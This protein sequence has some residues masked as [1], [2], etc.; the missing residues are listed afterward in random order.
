[1]K[2]MNASKLLPKLAFYEKLYIWSLLSEPLLFFV[3]LESSVLGIPITLS[4]VLQFSF[5]FILCVKYISCKKTIIIYDLLSVQNQRI[6]IYIFIVFLSS[7]A[8]L[9]SGAY[10]YE[11][12]GLL[13]FSN[14]LRPLFE[15]FILLYYFIYFL[16]LP[17]YIVHTKKHLSYLMKWL[18]NIFIFVVFIGM[19]DVLCNVIGFDLIP[20]HLVDSNWVTVGLRFH[21]ILGEPRDAFVY[22]LFILSIL[23]LNAAIHEE[24]KYKYFTMII[25]FTCLVFTQSFSGVVGIF[26]SLILLVVFTGIPTK[27]YKSTLLI[28]CLFILIGIVVSEYSLRINFYTQMALAIPNILQSDSIQPYLI[29]VHYPT[30]IVHAKH[31]A[32]LVSVQ[33]PDIIP[34]WV[35][36]HKIIN[37]D[38]FS[39]LFG[40]GIGSASFTTN[41]FIN[42]VG[43]NN[44]RG[45][46]T[47]L[48]FESGVIGTYIYILM[49]IKPMYNLKLILSNKQQMI[50]LISAIFL[51]G[52][53]L[54]HR[55]NLIFMF[56]G[57]VIAVIKIYSNPL[58]DFKLRLASNEK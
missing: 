28:L 10:N 21:S 46:I 56:V 50:I 4:R 7:I 20:R 55:S 8:G 15:F 24:M 9:L 42:E 1:M 26:I 49:L 25:I 3:L 48:L 29:G 6:Y 38:F 45:Q 34:L 58:K 19:I 22:L 41:N 39:V 11:S 18:K 30:D 33:A 31:L 17:K 44:P 35:F 37:Y 54:G 14:T 5:F 51:C 36:L 53:A 13:V 57:I 43:V 47:R 32:Y 12:D 27:Y 23:F 52:A 16:I 40:S 2:K